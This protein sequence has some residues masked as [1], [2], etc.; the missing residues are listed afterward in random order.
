VFNER[1][2]HMGFYNLQ[3]EK[4]TQGE[5]SKM[6]RSGKREVSKDYAVGLGGS[7][8]MIS[9]VWLGLDHRSPADLVEGEGLPVIFETMVFPR[10]F[11]DSDEI[12]TETDW[13]DRFSRKYSTL[14]DAK[15]GHLETVEMVRSGGLDG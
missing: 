11:R 13:L 10:K 5:W 12:E 6:F 15:A 8:F 7:E 4:I 9:T 2:I 14:E 1:L 3:G